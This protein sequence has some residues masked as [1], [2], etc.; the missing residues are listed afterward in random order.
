MYCRQCE[1]TMKGIA[2]NLSRG[3]CGKPAEV[4]DLQD[5]LICA[6]E[7]IALYGKELKDLGEALPEADLAIIEGLFTT[8]TNVNFDAAKV[9]ALI[10]GA[11]KIKNDLR[12]LYTKKTGKTLAQANIT[13]RFPESDKDIISLKEILLLGLK[14]MGA[15]AS[16]AHIL[17]YD[18]KDVNYFFYK[19]LSA[20]SD[21][22]L[23]ADDL[24]G[25]IIEFGKVNFKCLELLDK[26]NTTTF[27]HPEPTKVSIGPKKGPAI[28]I[29]GHDL[30]DLKMLLEQTKGKGIN[31]Y[32][33]GE[34]LPALAY[35]ELKK[36]PHLAGH[37]GT[38][39]QNQRKEFDNIPAAIL[40]TTN[41]IQEPLPNYKDRIFTTG[42]VQFPEVVHIDEK[43]GAKDFGPVIKKAIELGGFKEDNITK[44]ITIGFAGNA[45]M[46]AAG[47]VVELVKE[48]KIKHFF[49]LGGCDGAKPGRNYYTE[50]A[51]SL[52]ADTVILT[53]ACGKFRFNTLDLGAI[54]GIPRLLDCGQCND[55][56]SA[57]KIA[58]ALASAFNC[59]VNDLPLSFIL[60]WYEQKAVCVLLTLLSLGIKN[61]KIG[62]SLPAFV[63]ENV[64][65]IL[66]DKFGLGAI[67]TPEK[68]IAEA[69]KK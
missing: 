62:P 56:Y 51:A 8:I 22:T 21:T 42:L 18:D 4:A 39:W 41:C 63:S 44:E 30:L 33:H 17:G 7:E 49:L 57:I 13:S 53:L 12:S 40:M 37:F 9:E 29:S 69:L 68:D 67:S 43:N 11:N 6:L 61:I 46:K 64:L 38:A 54:E 32:T 26:A 1:Q 36:H 5:K 55:S 19:G 66:I 27:G 45:V 10:D 15:Y 25:L 23:S 65:N 59:G 58:S 34:M 3:V 50:L 60:S 2:C 16:H 35:P 14:G 31:I 20:L 24:L 28:I 52:P 47:K 48:G